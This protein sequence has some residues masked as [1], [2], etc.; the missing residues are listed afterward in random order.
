MIMKILNDEINDRHNHLSKRKKCGIYRIINPNGKIYV[1]QSKDIYKRWRSYKKRGCKGQVKLE[2]SFKK[3]GIEHHVFQILEQCAEESLNEREIYWG[4]FFN[5]LADENLTLK[6]GNQNAMISETTKKKI[7]KS[8][9]GR[10]TKPCHP[11]TKK[12][13]SEAHVGMRHLEESKAKMRRSKIGKATWNKG[14]K[15][16]KEHG[17]KIAES[18]KK[19]VVRPRTEEHKKIMSEMFKGKGMIPILQLDRKMTIIKEWKGICIAGKSCNINPG[20]ISE[21]AKNKR[22][23][24][25]GFIWRYKS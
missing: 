21:C 11:D 19:R 24:A 1:G 5:V 4:L 9:S 18:N 7:S 8:L 10:K 23:T 25:G 3:Y 17:A 2:R 12:K 13:I 14:K 22:K 16:S 20:N 15:I 6:L